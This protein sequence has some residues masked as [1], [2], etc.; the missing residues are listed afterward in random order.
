M[1]VNQTPMYKSAHKLSIA[2]ITATIL[3]IVTVQEIQKNG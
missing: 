1:S 3:I 2:V